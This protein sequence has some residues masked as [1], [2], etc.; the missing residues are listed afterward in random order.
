MIVRAAPGPTGTERRP[1]RAD[2]TLLFDVAD[3]AIR[4]SS[5][6]S[7]ATLTRLAERTPTPLEPWST[8]LRDRFVGVLAAGHGAIPVIESL[9]HVD[10]W[11]RYLPEWEAVRSR[12][13]R[14]AYHR[15]TVDRHLLEA[16]ANAAALADRVA[17]PDLLVLGALLHDIAKGRPGDHSVVGAELAE[18]HRHRRGW[19]SDEID[20]TGAA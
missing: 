2:S 10:L 18:R 16:A 12:P 14:N 15:F 7:R 3:V 8:G 6:P 5:R 4:T 9:D 1:G 13:Q 20:R 19:V 17:R 11:T